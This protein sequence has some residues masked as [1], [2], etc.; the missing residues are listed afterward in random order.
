MGLQVVSRRCLRR[1]RLCRSGD[2]RCQALFSIHGDDDSQCGDRHPPVDADAPPAGWGAPDQ[3]HR[4]HH[5]LCDDGIGPATPRLRLCRSAPA[6]P[7]T[8]QPA[9]VVRPLPQASRWRRSMVELRTFDDQMLLIT[10]GQGAVGVAGVM[11]ASI[12]RSATIRVGRA[13][14][15]GE[16]ANSSTSGAPVRSLLTTEA[17]TRFKAGRS[18]ADAARGSPRGRADARS[19]E[20]DDRP[21]RADLYPGK[22]EKRTIVYDPALANRLL[23]M[24]IPWAEQLRGLAGAGVRR[25]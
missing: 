2:R 10:D 19:G 4:G 22:P 6:R 21:C 12:A 24:E 5:E 15:G 1:N 17:S 3:Q 14:R 25:S 11:E 23:G 13:A 20:R 9:I 16:L 18:R 8:A 7:G